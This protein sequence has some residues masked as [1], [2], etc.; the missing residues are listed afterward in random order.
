MSPLKIASGRPPTRVGKSV[1]VGPGNGEVPTACFWKFWTE[2]NEIYAASR[3]GGHLTKIS[4][5][6]SGQIHM[7]LGPRNTLTFAPPIAVGDDWLHAIEIRFLIGPGSFTPP[8][9]L[10]KL[11]KNDKALL[12]QVS[13][14][15]VFLLNLLVGRSAASLPNAFVNCAQIWQ[16]SL[17]DS[18]IAVLIGRILPM[19]RENEKQL[20]FIRSELNPRANFEGKLTGHPP[21]LECI[22]AFWS[23]GGNVVFVVPMGTEG[24]RFEGDDREADTTNSQ[25]IR[26]AGPTISVPISAP[27]G[28]IV[29]TLSITGATS[30]IAL[31]KNTNV[32]GILGTLT[33]SIDE[34]ALRF[35]EQF[36]R[37]SVAISCVPTIGNVQPKTWDY[38][39]QTRFDGNQLNVSIGAISVALR[40]KN[41]PVPMSVLKDDEELLMRAPAVEITLSANREHPSVSASLPCSFRLRDSAK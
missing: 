3:G 37:P 13:P 32:T 6:A 23:P 5:H 25:Q 34:E 35:G 17:R 33:L 15:N 8:P 12:I 18:R 4:V 30:D 29:A 40:N 22:H 21:Y 31:V 39:L 27:N 20:N 14:N 36:T 19:D 26:I 7:H 2:G 11:K 24:Y 9:S 10:T 38:S 28:A 16:S 1:R 41:L